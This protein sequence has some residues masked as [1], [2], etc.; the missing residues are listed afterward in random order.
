M[1]QRSPSIR[2][3]SPEAQRPDLYLKRLLCVAVLANH[4]RR[5]EAYIMPHRAGR[6]FLYRDTQL[7]MPGLVWI[8]Q[9]VHRRCRG[10]WVTLLCQQ[11]FLSRGRYEENELR[12][13]L[14]ARL[15][16][17]CHSWRCS[18]V[19]SQQQLVAQHHL[20]SWGTCS[21]SYAVFYIIP[22]DVSLLGPLLDWKFSW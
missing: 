8:T 4:P 19:P 14:A 3:W 15:R 5:H 1:V 2:E 7:C 13:A 17:C 9:G 20:L 22:R 18:R 21:F 6:E 10:H 12:P 11:R 16:P